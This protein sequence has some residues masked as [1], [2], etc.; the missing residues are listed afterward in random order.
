MNFRVCIRFVGQ[1]VTLFYRLRNRPGLERWLGRAGCVCVCLWDP[2]LDPWHYL[3][4]KIK[5]GVQILNLL[6]LASV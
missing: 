3:E 4:L 5:E 1:I 6:N 2:G